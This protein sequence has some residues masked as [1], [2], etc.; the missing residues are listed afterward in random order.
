MQIL[1]V[2]K[3]IAI[4]ILMN[5]NLTG[6]LYHIQKKNIKNDYLQNCNPSPPWA[7]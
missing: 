7:L 2:E 5:L 3:R 4:K 1:R 6:N